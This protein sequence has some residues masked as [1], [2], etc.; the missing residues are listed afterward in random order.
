MCKIKYYTWRLRMPI[1]EYKCSKCNKSFSVLQKAGAS[2]KDTS[3]PD[4]GSK[5]V[6]KLLSAFSCS[7]S[8][9]TTFPERLGAPSHACGGGGGG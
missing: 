5:S 1:Y 4:C 6:K 9:G 3:C 8:G 7:V 2:E